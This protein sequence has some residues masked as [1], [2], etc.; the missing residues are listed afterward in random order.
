MKESPP[1]N[2]V[3][4]W[5]EKVTPCH[6]NR[7]TALKCLAAGLVVTSNPIP[8]WAARTNRGQPWG[9]F[10]TPPTWRSL[11]VATGD[12]LIVPAKVSGVAIDAVLDSG[13]G[14]SIISKSLAAK[15]GMTNLEP[16]RIN[17]L[18][19]K[20]PVG[21]VRNVAVMLG[22]YA[23]VLPFAVIADLGAVSAAFG[24][25]IDMLLGADVL[26]GGCVALDFATRR[27]AFEK[28]ASFVPGP[29]WT[30]LSLG[31]G[32]KQELFVLASIAGLDPV[33]LMLD[34]GSSSAL[35]LSS[36]YIETHALLA[37]KPVSTAA[38]GGVE[39]VQIVKSFIADTVS[40]GPLSIAS[41]PALALDH[42]T[43]VS[44]VGNVGMP[45]LGQFDIV[46]DVF[47]GLLWLR[48][49]PPRGRLP[50]LKDRSGL[51][52]AV[53]ATELTVVHVAS[54]SP[55]DQAGWVLGEHVVAVNGRVIDV[56][57]TRGSLWQWRYGPAG[58]RV[59][60]KLADGTTRMLTLAD[61]Y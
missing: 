3:E 49:S 21:L 5:A 48:A 60:L 34:F 25:P 4:S 15:L 40:L 7:R 18:G 37:G 2:S 11:E 24:R 28:P 45:L 23:P 52:L 31:H 43:S 20:A 36:A 29:E 51:G 32:A 53:S 27:F 35:I 39:G 10:V 16:R 14:A 58:S 46:L 6:T 13:S 42:W 1:T 26:A 59:T 57:Y 54:G 33:P 55:A 61:Y 19:G 41:V 9:G 44:T 47:K 30:T 8:L 50:M 56:F 17:G 12:T 22:A 38:L